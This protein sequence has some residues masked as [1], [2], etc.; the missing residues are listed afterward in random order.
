MWYLKLRYKGFYLVPIPSYYLEDEKRGFNHVVELYNRLKLPMLNI[1]EKT[2]NVKQAKL[3][4]KDREN[5]KNRFKC[6]DLKIIKDKKILIV[7]DVYT[8]GSSVMAII[9]LLKVGKPK[10]IEVL[11][12]AKNILKPKNK[13]INHFVLVK[14]NT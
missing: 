3:K 10:K 4:K 2:E 12:M 6:S 13:N 5:I 8:T 1:M 11:V 7:D 9:D 14:S